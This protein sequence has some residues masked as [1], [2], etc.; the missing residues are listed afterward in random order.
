MATRAA[1]DHPSFARAYVRLAEVADERGAREH[2]RRLVAGLSG[3]VLEVGAGH[4]AS[5]ALYPRTVGRVVALE[6]EST[7]RAHAVRAAQ[8]APVSVSV[9]AGTAE[10]PP[11]A[12]GTLDAIVFSLVL[13]SVPDQ[14][15][16]LG[17]SFS[18]LRPGGVLAV[19]EHVRSQRRVLGLL[20][21]AVAPA[22]ARLAAG[23][24]PNRDTVAA[25]RQAGFDVE[26]VERFRFSP[27]RSVPATEHVLVRARRPAR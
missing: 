25:V 17:A 11:V 27:R 22:W 20:E 10:Q 15:T 18:A 24:H 5:F 8:T 19:Y 1:H 4:G 7:L 14:R 2:R 3:T 21:D 26:Q 9:V 13:C 23:C 12:A 16:A 6:P